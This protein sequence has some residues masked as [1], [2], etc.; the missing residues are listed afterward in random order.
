M[1][2]LSKEEMDSIQAMILSL[3]EKKIALGDTVIH[4]NKIIKEISE[5]ESDYK[6]S[7]KMLVEKYG[8]DSVINVKTGE[9]TKKQ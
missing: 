2:K 6:N 7:E 9:V 5:L 4:Q 8:A 3:T 1:A